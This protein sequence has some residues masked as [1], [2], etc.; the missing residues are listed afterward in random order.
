[1]EAAAQAAA[2]AGQAVQ[3][4]PKTPG[5]PVANTPSGLVLDQAPLVVEPVVPKPAVG[6]GSDM[7][8]AIIPQTLSPASD[9][10]QLATSSG[11]AQALT[12]SGF[13][14]LATPEGVRNP[15]RSQD[16]E[17]PNKEAEIKELQR[18]CALFEYQTPA[19]PKIH[20]PE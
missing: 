7:T 5:N 16:P 3:P 2:A 11:R 12:D 20:I 13:P 18:L 14:L 8:V 10:R 17:I 15:G 9:Q 19:H 6:T 1:M 4:G